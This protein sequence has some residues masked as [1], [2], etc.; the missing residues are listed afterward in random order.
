MSNTC[1]HGSLLPLVQ[2]LLLLPLALHHRRKLGQACLLAPQALRLCCQLAW[3]I[4]ALQQCLGLGQQRL[5]RGRSAHRHGRL[6]MGL[7]VW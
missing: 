6:A 3:R 5:P 2:H 4:Q 1:S 7:R